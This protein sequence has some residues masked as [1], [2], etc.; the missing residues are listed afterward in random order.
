M[1]PIHVNMLGADGPDR[2]HAS[3]NY[4]LC[5]ALDQIRLGIVL[6]KMVAEGV[7][8]ANVATTFRHQASA[9]LTA[10]CNANDQAFG[11]DPKTPIR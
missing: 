2:L 4:Q 8:H 10:I 5:A 11:R 3:L 6:D 1:K 7:I 9:L